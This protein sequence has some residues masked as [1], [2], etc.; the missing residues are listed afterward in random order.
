MAKAGGG[1]GRAGG[2]GGLAANATGG[3]VRTIAGKRYNTAEVVNRAISEGRDDLPAARAALTRL[4]HTNP[5]DAM[6]RDYARQARVLGN[7]ERITGSAAS[8]QI[9]K[10]NFSNAQTIMNSF[11]SYLNRR[12]Q[13]QRSRWT[14]RTAG[15][16]R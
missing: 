4:G 8:G 10:W 3:T 2:G 6:V 14:A 16:R 11:D 9:G 5:P 7:I 13:G 12:I 15:N 1:S